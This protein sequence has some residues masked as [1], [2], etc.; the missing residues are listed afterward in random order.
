MASDLGHNCLHMSQG[1]NVKLILVKIT[2]LSFKLHY[3]EDYFL[4]RF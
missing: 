4:E 3:S 2:I 1:K